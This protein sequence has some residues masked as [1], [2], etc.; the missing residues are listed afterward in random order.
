VVIDKPE[1]TD[2]PDLKNINTTVRRTFLKRTTAVALIAF[3]PG[4]SAWAGIAGSIVASGHGSDFNQGKSTVLQNQRYF[5]HIADD[6]KD[7]TF[8]EVFGEYPFKDNGSIRNNDL[9]FSSILKTRKKDERGEGFI[10][11][12]LVV[13]YLNAIEHNQHGIYYPVLDQY[14][15]NAIA[16]AQYLYDSTVDNPRQAASELFAIIAHYE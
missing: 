11:V 14:D 16:F 12:A 10:N 6:Y 4:R 1:E 5:K 9:K 8:Y 3:I 7:L 2:S 15:G 13:M